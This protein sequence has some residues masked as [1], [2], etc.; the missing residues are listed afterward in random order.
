MT[1]D[2][3]GLMRNAEP[4]NVMEHSWEVAVIAHALALIRNQYFKGQWMLMLLPQPLYFM[5]PVKS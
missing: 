5:M 4:E 2:S 3:W 1:P